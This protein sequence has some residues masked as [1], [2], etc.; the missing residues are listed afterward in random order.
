MIS[1]GETIG[2]DYQEKLN[3]AIE[4]IS[5]M[6]RELEPGMKNKEI[7]FATASM[8]NKQYM[9][10]KD[11]I[12]HIQ[13]KLEISFGVEKSGIPDEVVLDLWKAITSKGITNRKDYERLIERIGKG[14]LQKSKKRGQKR[15]TQEQADEEARQ[16]LS[17][18]TVGDKK[19]IPGSFHLKLY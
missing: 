2:K 19:K 15:L 8:V 10:D 6:V 1:N 17:A 14:K 16:S 9:K 12:R 18:T 13:T 7:K 5:A 4:Y 11:V 3:N